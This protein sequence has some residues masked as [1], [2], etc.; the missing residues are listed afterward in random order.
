MPNSTADLRP[1]RPDQATGGRDPA[2]LRAAVLV[3]VHA[4]LDA[5]HH[6]ETAESEHLARRQLSHLIWSWTEVN[7]KWGTRFVT[8]AALAAHE[9]GLGWAVNHE[10]VWPRRWLVDRLLEGETPE[11]VLGQFGVG[12]VVLKDEHALLNDLPSEVLGWDRYKAV[13]IEVVDRASAGR[14]ARAVRRAAL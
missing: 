7:G 3:H 1:Y 9:S 4:V 10:H 14:A 8:S 13:G 5:H 6:I 2:L 12:C 11:Y